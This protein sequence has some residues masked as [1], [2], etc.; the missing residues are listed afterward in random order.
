MKSRGGCWWPRLIRQALL[1]AA[2]GLAAAPSGAAEA[3]PAAVATLDPAMSAVD[4]SFL[5]AGEKPAGRRGFLAARG[6]QLVFEDGTPVRFWGTN[7]AAYALFLTPRDAVRQQA[8]RLSRLGFNLVRIHHH[9]SSW[10]QPNVFGTDAANTL[11]VDA[12]MLER[13]DWWIKCLKD[14]GIYVWL[15]LH[16][17]RMLRKGDGI[18]AI[19]EVDR[20][21]KGGDLRGYNYVNP[22]I[23]KAMSNFNAAYITHVNRYTGLAYAKDPAIAA[24]LI[25]NENDLTFHFGNTLL[26]DKGVPWH[27]AIYM[28]EARDF[29]ARW[30]LSSGRVSRAWEHGPAKLFL[31]DLEHRFDAAMITQL[32]E[33]GVRAPIVT[34]STWGNPLSALPALT[35]GDII[36]A[37]AG[38][39]V[40]EMG[41]DPRD[42][43]SLVH[44]ISAARVAGK[45]LS[46]TEWGV[47]EQG[48]PAP[49]R[50][51][52]PLFVAAWASRQG[53]NAMMHFAYSQEPFGSRQ[54]PSI[55]HAYNDPAMIPALAA[56]AL[57]FRRQDVPEDTTRYVFTPGR[58]IF[59]EEI[60]A[61]NSPALRAAAEQGRLAIA[62]P[63][64]R[65]L[66]WLAPG[67]VAA[68]AITF[69]DPLRAPPLPRT[70]GA[71]A[72]RRDV[73]RNLFTIDTPR[74]QA[75]M[76]R[77]A[78]Q[79]IAL[80]DVTIE[81]TSEMA[82]IAVQSADARPI[83][84]STQLIVSL[85]GPAT[86]LES[87]DVPYRIEAVRGKLTIRA[88]PGLQVQALDAQ[89]KGRRIAARYVEGRYEIDL[90]PQTGTFWLQIL[91]SPVGSR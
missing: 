11:S 47:E 77:L 21:G 12:Q 85:A 38:G 44:W 87:G 54:T 53:W 19:N 78:G 7:V 36:D 45:P 65:E 81:S 70:A 27:S 8:R 4:L 90:V 80:G 48:R 71:S 9:D 84:E 22:S 41:R 64:T 18:D 14:E 57:L 82:T 52:A 66:P 46:V 5:N 83:R 1:A 91:Q 58:R 42:A 37:H 88:R 6:E 79:R 72:T 60:S 86:A 26:G 76:G 56:G 28:R 33:L 63:A 39:S 49:D 74:T 3:A 43:A 68:G 73:Q 89:G 20:G 50:Q 15:D 61:G 34:T 10:V 2:C 51:T 62:M 30:N 24:F 35:S 13:L 40:G 31:N 23:Q 67:V 75:A 25:T 29:A 55:Y 59:D 32:R 17:G 16:V 69:S